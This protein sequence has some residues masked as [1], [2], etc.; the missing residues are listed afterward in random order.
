MIIILLINRSN[1]ERPKIRNLKNKQTLLNTQQHA[2]QQTI[3]LKHEQ[4]H[5]VEVQKS[6]L[7]QNRSLIN[8][9]VP[10]QEINGGSRRKLKGILQNTFQNYPW[11]SINWQIQ[12]HLDKLTPCKTKKKRIKENIKTKAILLLDQPRIKNEFVPQ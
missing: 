12:K 8:G 9:N 10:H 1:N 5:E 7:N 4:N 2:R 3:H 6:R 11:W